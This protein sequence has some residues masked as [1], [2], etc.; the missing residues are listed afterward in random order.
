[1]ADKEISATIKNVS[2]NY[3]ANFKMEWKAFQKF[4]FKDINRVEY[5][6]E[7]NVFNKNKKA[8]N[9]TTHIINN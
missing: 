9:Q 4:N 2:A 7:N 3:Y 6:S 5:N 1:M 8:S